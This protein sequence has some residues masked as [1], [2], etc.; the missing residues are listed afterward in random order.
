MSYIVS[1]A[2]AKAE[3]TK[4]QKGR[5]LIMQSTSTVLGSEVIYRLYQTRRDGTAVYQV[6]AGYKREKVY[7]YAGR[8]RNQAENIFAIV[9]RGCVTPCTLP[10]IMEDLLPDAAEEEADAAQI[11][12]FN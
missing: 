7:C 5:V 9:A 12:A 11:F 3:T 2:S 10:F 4:Q 1:S 6:Y 8:D